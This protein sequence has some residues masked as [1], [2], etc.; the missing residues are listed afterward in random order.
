MLEVTHESV[1]RRPPRQSLISRA[2]ISLKRLFLKIIT[3]IS[4]ALGNR[5]YGAFVFLFIRVD[6]LKLQFSSLRATSIHHPQLQHS[7]E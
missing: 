6:R 5:G 2:P 4:A 3:F 1:D 7:R